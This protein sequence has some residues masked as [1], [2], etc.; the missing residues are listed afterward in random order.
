M[1]FYLFVPVT[2]IKDT[3]VILSSI[4]ATMSDQKM[5]VDSILLPFTKSHQIGGLQ[6]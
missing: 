6:L 5:T 4:V 2:S 3:Q 1:M